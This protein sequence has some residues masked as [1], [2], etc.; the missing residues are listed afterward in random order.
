[1][2][3]HVCTV[4]AGGPALVDVNESS[5]RHPA[6][7]PTANATTAKK[8]G[9]AQRLASGEAP[10]DMLSLKAAIHS[11]V[12]GVSSFPFVDSNGSLLAV[13]NAE[14]SPASPLG[15]LNASRA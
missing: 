6:L 10:W 5:P 2:D 1:M 11:A 8:E 13:Q 15:S 12:P 9:I 7:A 4:A 3:G 14:H